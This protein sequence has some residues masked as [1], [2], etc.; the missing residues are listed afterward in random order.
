MPIHISTLSPKYIYLI[1]SGEKTVEGRLYKDKF[2]KWKVNDTVKFINKN[3]ENDNVSCIIEDIKRYDT[4]K[5]MLEGEGI[6]NCLPKITDISRGVDIYYNIPNYKEG[7]K[8]Y[9]VVAF[10]IKVIKDGGN[11]CN[12]L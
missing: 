2:T 6:E 12:I 4:F 9:G 10:R 1:Q 5:E 8:I 11:E 7:E 3:N